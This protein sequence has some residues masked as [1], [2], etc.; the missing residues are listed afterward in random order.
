MTEIES[1]PIPG[2][3]WH[4]DM[5]DEAAK[6]GFNCGPASLCAVLDKTPA[7]I[8]PHLREFER[9]GYTNPSLMAGIL[10]DL[11]VPFRR[12][13][14]SARQPALGSVVWPVWGLARIQWG[15]PWTRPGVPMRARYRHTHWIGFRRGNG[16]S[17]DVVFDVNALS[18]GGW[19]SFAEWA[20]ELIPWLLDQVEP[21]ASGAWWPT[22]CWE[23]RNGSDSVR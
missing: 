4:W 21:K 1:G 3:G 23:I 19:I 22:H 17:H 9:K 13:F 5:I 11:H 12:V 16:I 10:R 14:Q 8:R 2:L 15:G 18:V 6:W 20:N 7:E